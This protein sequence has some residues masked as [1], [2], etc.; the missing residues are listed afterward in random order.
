MVLLISIG[1]CRLVA[2]DQPVPIDRI[3][4]FGYS[5]SHGYNVKV[6]DSMIIGMGT[7]KRVNTPQG[8]HMTSYDMSGNIDSSYYLYDSTF[9]RPVTPNDF[10]D[11]VDLGE[12]RIFS[13]VSAGVRV[14]YEYDV[15]NNAFISIDTISEGKYSNRLSRVSAVEEYNEIKYVFTSTVPL[16]NAELA[17]LAYGAD[18]TLTVFGEASGTI[19]TRELMV[20]GVDEWYASCRRDGIPYLYKRKN[21]EITNLGIVPKNEGSYGTGVR[22]SAYIADEGIFILLAAR[23][24][25]NDVAYWGVTKV[26]TIG[27][28]LWKRTFE[29]ELNIEE[30]NPVARSWSFLRGLIPAVENDGVVFVGSEYIRDTDTTGY[31]NGVIGKLDYEGNILWLR[32]YRNVVGAD[33][34]NIIYDIDYDSYGGY[35]TYGTV[36]YPYIDPWS[37]SAWLMRLDK[38]GLPIDT[39][40]NTVEIETL[41]EQLLVYPNPSNSTITLPSEVSLDHVDIYTIAGG[42]LGSYPCIDKTVLIADLPSGTYILKAEK[43]K[44]SYVAKFVKL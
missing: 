23:F 41:V 33:Y 13:C 30:V 3:D 24:E 42:H 4:R 21:G 15:Y 43:N 14:C 25:E 10:H 36:R 28:T 34:R 9:F 35:V 19:T 16:E 11:I 32:K 31:G 12:G 1:Q 6:L 38:D 17:I 8:M 26:D 27:N 39:T 22:T 5:W 40:T 20:T 29:N 18:T 2:Q 7:A 37:R 44:K